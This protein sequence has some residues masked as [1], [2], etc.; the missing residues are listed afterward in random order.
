MLRATLLLV[1]LCAV[2]VNGLGF[3]N[4]ALLPEDLLVTG[5][6]ALNEARLRLFRDLIFTPTNVATA[7]PLGNGVL[8][9]NYQANNV[10]PFNAASAFRSSLWFNPVAF[11]VAAST[12]V[13][14]SIGPDVQ[15]RSLLR[16]GQRVI[17]AT[18]NGGQRI[19]L[20]GI[21]YS[22]V[23]ENN[24]LGALDIGSGSAAA[25]RFSAY[26]NQANTIFTPTQTVNQLVRADA[27]FI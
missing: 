24:V 7:L 27:T 12:G 20:N 13:I 16:E 10:D 14:V 19:Q 18:N 17:Y 26:V 8:I 2:S 3:L 25:Q 1:A 22:L 15:Q 6:A 23:T 5:N 11:N 21:L 4:S 9:E